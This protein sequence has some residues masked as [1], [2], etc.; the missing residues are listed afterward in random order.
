MA[1]NPKEWPP[2]PAGVGKSPGAY[3]K[4]RKKATLGTGAASQTLLLFRRAKEG[5]IRI[6]R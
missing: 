6:V 4:D 5:T 2:V 3:R 1:G